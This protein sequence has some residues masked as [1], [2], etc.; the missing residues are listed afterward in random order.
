MI[1]IFCLLVAFFVSLASIA[2][3]LECV[4]KNAKDSLS[5][6]Y[7]AYQGS[8]QPQGLLLLFPSFMETPQQAALETDIQHE[9]CERGIVT[10]FAS[11]QYGTNSFYVDSLSQYAIDS[12]IVDLQ[13]K[14]D[15]KGK[16][17]YLGGFSL[18]GAGAVKYAERAYLSTSLIR[19]N[20]IFAIDPPLDFERF[21]CSSENEVRQS[22]SEAAASE[23]KYF[24]QRL[25]YEFQ[26]SP[27]INNKS[28]HI[29]SP[30]SYSDSMNT[31]AKT[32][33]RCP[34]QL[35]CEPDL[36]W[37]MENRNRSLYDLNVMDCSV[38]INYLLIE[39]NK[40]AV[41]TLTSNKGYRKSSGKR[42]PHSCSI[43]SSKE[44][45]NWLLKF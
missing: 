10:V 44:M 13:Q 26:Y 1:K 11:L 14:Y 21:Y 17:L 25:Q 15:L 24:S 3:S 38:L 27:H 37:Q 7:I 41:L 16:P 8:R 18:G 28:Y 19:P 29:I 31:N 22:K 23:A 43:L 4:Y 34:V 5:N 36:I 33:L 12:L 35:V 30:Y 9:A 45:L 20:A 39:G 32:L 2:Q 40:N 42:N 6:Y